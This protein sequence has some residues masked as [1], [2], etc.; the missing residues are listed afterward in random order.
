[1]TE[2]YQN[3]KRDHNK[4]PYKKYYRPQSTMENIPTNDVYD[5]DMNNLKNVSFIQ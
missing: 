4:Q 3:G 5:S 1:M 2:T